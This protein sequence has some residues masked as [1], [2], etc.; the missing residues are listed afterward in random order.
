VFSVKITPVL[1][2][3]HSLLADLCRNVK[4]RIVTECQRHGVKY[5]PFSSCRVTQTYDAGA[6][7]YFYFVMNY[8]DLRHGGDPVHIYEE[9][10]Q[11]ARDEV[12]ANGGSLSHH[13]GIGKIRTK[14]IKQAVSDLGVGTMASIKQYLDPQNIF[15]SKNLIPEIDEQEHQQLKAKL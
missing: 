8:N 9:V 7:V 6:C 14:W 10:E 3:S 12:L 13:H 5:P 1:S 4:K 15:G 11:A 2:F